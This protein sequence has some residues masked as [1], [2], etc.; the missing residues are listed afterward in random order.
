MNTQTLEDRLREHYQRIADEV[1][2]MDRSVD[3]AL[4]LNGRLPGTHHRRSRVMAAVAAAIVAATLGG[5]ALLPRSNGDDPFRDTVDDPATIA[6]T[7]QAPVTTADPTDR[8]GAIADEPLPYVLDLPG[9]TVSPSPGRSYVDPATG[10]VSTTFVSADGGLSEILQLIRYPTRSPQLP[11]PAMGAEID[12]PTGEAHYDTSPTRPDAVVIR[13]DLGD[14]TLAVR[15][16]RMNG[17]DTIAAM[18]DFA[19]TGTVTTMQSLGA[20]GYDLP[21][22]DLT[23]VADETSTSGSQVA[24]PIAM[25]ELLWQPPGYGCCGDQPANRATIV[26]QPAWRWDSVSADSGGASTSFAMWQV[27]NSVRWMQV[28]GPTETFDSVL[29]AIRP[30]EVVLTD[31]QIVGHLVILRLGLDVFVVDA[32]AGHRPT[33]DAAN[34]YHHLG[35][36]APDG[37]VMDVPPVLDGA[38]IGG[39]LARLRQGD[40]IVWTPANASAAITFVVRGT[41]ESIDPNKE[42]HGFDAAGLVLI[43]SPSDFATEASASAAVRRVVVYA[44]PSS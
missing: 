24:P 41:V 17:D 27:P 22:W 40:E 10:A 12:V 35:T 9:T 19:S 33:Q 6:P 44:D 26:G 15:A 30:V 29:A 39:T 1:T 3:A 43:G 34:V 25:L 31:Q 37:S 42:R 14:S 18:L 5:L 2:I 8:G 32:L 11:V 7:T 21:S 20:T 16:F 38:A 4:H 28:S 13:W 23:Y 36:P